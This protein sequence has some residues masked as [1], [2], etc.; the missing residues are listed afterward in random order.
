VIEPGDY[1]EAIDVVKGRHFTDYVDARAQQM[2]ES[3]PTTEGVGT[4][5]GLNM[6]E[7]N[8]R[9]IPENYRKIL[10]R[11]GL[12]MRD[13]EEHIATRRTKYGDNITVEKWLEN[14]AN[15]DV[16]YDGKKYVTHDLTAKKEK[17]SG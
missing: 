2:L 10:D 5:G 14:A 11:A 6:S 3:A 13:L 12:T 9:E 15:S 16:I 7:P 17:P 1:N 8:N 4:G